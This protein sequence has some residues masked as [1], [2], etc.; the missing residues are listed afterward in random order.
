[1]NVK[2]WWIGILGG[3]GLLA[4]G[5]GSLIYLEQE[6]L[7]RAQE[8]VAETRTKIDGH[9]RLIQGTPTL[10]R[11]VIVL[12]EMSEVIKGILPDDEDVY[13]LNRTFQRFSDEAGPRI[14]G[15]KQTQNRTRSSAKQTAFDEVAYTITMEADAFQLLDFLDRLEGHERF[16]RVPKFR[17]GSAARAQVEKDGHAAHKISIDVETFVYDPKSTANPVEI[18]GY[19]RK[20]DLLVGEI[21]RRRQALLVKEY[22]YIGG[23]GRRDPWVDPRVPVSED[24]ASGLTVQEQMDRVQALADQTQAMVEQWGGMRQARNVIEEMVARADLEEAISR[25]EEEVRRLQ[26]DKSIRYVPSARRMQLDVIDVVAQV[27]QDLLAAEGGRG[28]SESKLQQ[29]LE[30]MNNHFD[31]EEYALMLDAYRLVSGQ[32][33]F[34]Q[35]DPIRKPF[36]IELRRLARIAETVREFEDY[37]LR[38]SGVA[39]RHGSPSVVIING[40]TLSVGELLGNELLVHEIT[41]EE[42]QFVFRGVILARRF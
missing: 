24:G 36:V 28:P 26:A 40:N 37:D 6:N 9:R 41:Q 25:I 17:I 7:A 20:R 31:R 18:E 12:R 22:N 23:R 29:V 16:M 5:V 34:V 8:E 38:V 32:L 19:D 1:M 39:I 13:N 2:R 21:N 33:D 4:A 3:G 35:A 15:L 11:E 14:R 27:R 10:E 42:V 30:A